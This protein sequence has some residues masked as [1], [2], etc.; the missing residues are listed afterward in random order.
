[1]PVNKP[2]HQRKQKD[3]PEKK[4]F[5]KE[6]SMDSGIMMSEDNEDKSESFSGSSSNADEFE[7]ASNDSDMKRNQ[8]ADSQKSWNDLMNEIS[9]K[10]AK[11]Q[12]ATKSD[13]TNT[14]SK[15][16]P[17]TAKSPKRLSPLSPVKTPKRLSPSSPVKTAVSTQKRKMRSCESIE[18]PKSKVRR[19]SLYQR[20]AK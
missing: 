7:C 16:K 4:D 19:L 5:V 20:G 12:N 11:I 10:K 8:S 9:T 14:K 18:I 3:I 13:L 2:N 1:M 15:L 6:K 17:N